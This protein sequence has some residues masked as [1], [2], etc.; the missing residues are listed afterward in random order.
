MPFFMF[1]HKSRLMLVDSFNIHACA[2]HSK[3]SFGNQIS[4]EKYPLC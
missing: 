3:Y 1:P 2:F 4:P